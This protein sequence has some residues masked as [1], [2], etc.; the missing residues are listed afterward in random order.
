[1]NVKK[2]WVPRCA[3]IRKVEDPGAKPNT[4]TFDESFWGHEGF[5]DDDGYS[6]PQLGSKYADQTYVFNTF[7][8]RALDN[9]WAGYRCC[10]FAYGQ[11]GAG[12]SYSMVDYGKNKVEIYNEVVQDLLVVPESRPR[13]GLDIRESK[14][15]GIYIDGVAKRPVDS[16]QAIEQ[17]IEDATQHRTVAST[18]MNA[19][20]S[21]A[22][23][24][25]CIEF[26]QVSKDDGR[27]STKVLMVNLVDLA[28]SEKAGQ[29]GATGQR[30]VE[31]SMISKSLSAVGNVIK[32]FASKSQGKNVMVPYRD[33]KLT[34]LL[35]NALG[36]SNKTIMICALSQASSNYAETLS[37][38]RYADRAKKIKNQVVDNENPQEKLMCV[39][40]RRKT[41]SS[42][43]SCQTSRR[44][45]LSVIWS[46]CKIR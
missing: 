37:T 18:A 34:R 45:L 16:Y 15:L 42:K 14:L 32:K 12:K 46:S 38:L 6:R 9:A 1:M 35:Q 11:T 44:I 33:S 7:G 23:T 17:A 36:G 20:S 2:G 39:N 27:E 30:L 3:S 24:V 43:S 5:E 22:H 25:T 21:R 28:G 10:L 8:T 13:K 41:Q 4:F 29:T 31:G 26:K 19:T 40:L